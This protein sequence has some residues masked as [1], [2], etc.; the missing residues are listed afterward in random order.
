[1]CHLRSLFLS[2]QIRSLRNNTERYTLT[3][4]PIEQP[5]AGATHPL[6]HP[7]HPD[8]NNRYFL[9]SISRNTKYFRNESSTSPGAAAARR[10]VHRDCERWKI[11]PIRLSRP[12][13]DE[14]TSSFLAFFDAETSRSLKIHATAVRQRHVSPA[15]VYKSRPTQ[16]ITDT[17]G[18]SS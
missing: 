18:L 8:I 17:R 15:F 6:T 5:P 1:M 14:H 4:S 7:P 11:H 3:H 13:W 12:A 2:L 16:P 9:I 10:G